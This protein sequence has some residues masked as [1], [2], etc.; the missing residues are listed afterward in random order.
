MNTTINPSLRTV[1]LHGVMASKFGRFHKF[2]L[3]T[4]STAEAVRALI[5]QHPAVSAY[6]VGAKD[7]GVGFTVFVGKR[8][9]T[10]DELQDPV[11]NEV[12]HIAPIIMGSK[13]GG[14]L[15]IIAGI[16]LIV[17]AAIY[18]V[19]TE[20]WADAYNVMWY[21]AA[22]IAGGA[23]SLLTPMP[24]GPKNRDSP[25]NAPSY[26]FNGAVNTQA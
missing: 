12:I 21:G 17:G 15:N 16:V 23:V 26:V 22:M 18:G 24:K 3:E 10:Q 7:R 8:N 1:R 19:Y 6:L 11:G 9:I 13:N 20:D 14:I 4:N 5:S 25:D 2:A